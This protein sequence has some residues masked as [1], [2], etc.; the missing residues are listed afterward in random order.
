MLIVDTSDVSV[1]PGVAAV[2]AIDWVLN[3]SRNPNKRGDA[4]RS[5]PALSSTYARQS[6][7][8]T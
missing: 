8:D 2:A 4:M 7:S 1:C 3:P 5:H 6:S